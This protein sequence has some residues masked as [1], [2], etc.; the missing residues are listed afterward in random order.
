MT[1]RL[2]II[3][4]LGSFALSCLASVS[5]EVVS[6]QLRS[7]Q[8]LS[9]SSTTEQKGEPALTWLH[10]TVLPSGTHR[11]EIRAVDDG[12]IVVAVV[13]PGEHQG[14]D[15]EGRVKHRVYHL[16]STLTQEWNSFPITRVAEPY[17]EPADH[18]IALVNDEIV[19]IYQTL[20]YQK[21]RRHTSGP[22]EDF[23]TDQSLLLARFSMDGEEVFRAPIV[24]R[25]SDIETDNFPDHCLLWWDDRLLVSSGAR[26]RMVHIREVTL[27]ASV[28]A[29]HVLPTGFQGIS[30]N[31]GNSMFV[32]G[33]QLRYFSSNS[34]AGNGA[35]TLTGLGTQFEAT[36]LAELG[37]DDDVERHFPTDSYML[38]D[39]TLVTYI[40][41]E[42]GQG[43]SLEENPYS[44]FIMILN[45]EYNVVE[46]IQLGEGGFAHVHPTMTML[47]D[48]LFVAWSKRTS[49]GPQV[50]IERFTISWLQT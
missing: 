22:S 23:A 3:L 32:Q 4:F 46:D 17:G 50:Q 2:A 37:G 16:D 48:E 38:G 13:K 24:D 1:R 18:R 29:D 12:S 43:M 34:P 49:Y 39:Y 33:N 25:T 8:W 20:N 9:F 31:I 47:G 19:V 41:R 14:Q 7:N 40:A 45:K 11:P 28:L 10:T 42:S 15:N 36:R 21:S 26:S 30:G 35:L 5:E 6:P 27:D 44:P